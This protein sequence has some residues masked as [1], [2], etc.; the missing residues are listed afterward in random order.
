M[1]NVKAMEQRPITTEQVSQLIAKTHN[2]KALGPDGINNSGLSGLLQLI[3][4]YHIT[5]I[6]SWRMPETFQIF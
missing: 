4:T 1:S 5:L 6:N 3:L 2:W